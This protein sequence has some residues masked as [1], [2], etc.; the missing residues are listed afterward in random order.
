MEK[1]QSMVACSALRWASHTATSRR[2]MASS[3][4]RRLRHWRCK[5]LNSISLWAAR[6][7]MGHD[8]LPRWPRLP[9]Q[10]SPV[11]TYGGYHRIASHAVPPRSTGVR[12]AARGQHSPEGAIGDEAPGAYQGGGTMGVTVLWSETLGVPQDYSSRSGSGIATFWPGRPA[13]AAPPGTA[14][15]HSQRQHRA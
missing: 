11:G 2:S 4:M 12:T 14:V 7:C 10:W 9:H 3:G 5:M 8:P 13:D 15:R 1:R 6:L